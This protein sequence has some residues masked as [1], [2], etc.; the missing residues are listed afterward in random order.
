MLA[1]ND[2]DSVAPSGKGHLLLVKPIVDD[3]A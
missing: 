3:S 1:L 2:F